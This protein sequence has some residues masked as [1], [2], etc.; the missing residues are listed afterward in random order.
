MS[1]TRDSTDD[2]RRA[3]ER[4]GQDVCV[5]AGPGSGKT[6]VL[7]ERFAWLVEE[8]G[9]DPARILAITF[10]EKAANEIKERLIERFASRCRIAELR[11]AIERAW[12]STIHGFCA[13]LLREN[14]IAAG[15]RAG[16]HGA[17]SS[18]GG[19][20]GARSG[21][22]TLDAD[23]SG[24]AAGNAAA[25]GGA[26]SF[27]T[28]RR[29]RKPD[30]AEVCWTCTNRCACRDCGNCPRLSQAEMRGR[31]ARRT[32]GRRFWRIERA[33]GKDLRRCADVASVC[34][35]CR[36]RSGHAS[37]SSSIENIHFNLGSSARTRARGAA[38]ELKNEIDP[39]AEAQWVGRWNADLLDCC[40]RRSRGSTPSIAQ[41]KREEAAVD[42]AD[43][44]EE[45]IRLLEE[46]PSCG[47]ERG[48]VRAY[49]DGR[50]AGHQSAAMAADQS[51][52]AQFLRGGRYQPVDLRLP[53]RRSGCCSRN[54][55]SRSIA[56]ARRST[57]CGRII[58]AARRFWRQFRDARRAG[59]NRASC[60]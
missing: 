44:E 49:P 52:P 41:K 28:R 22:G 59:R 21:G 6:R 48:T 35:R 32:G 16:F 33:G 40:A 57:S 9:V 5:V 20:A 46:I 36:R 1:V 45:T 27:D 60:R 42:F 13:R 56:A 23:V 39:V 19:P 34:W 7:I 53:L 26:G 51:D 29:S 38:D 50:V 3:V 55:A 4:T 11:E 58:A 14:A 17:R 2:Q 31:E 43:L 18:G 54:I 30:L 12:V 10:T 24:A 47:R 37:I 25:A 8:Q 15:L